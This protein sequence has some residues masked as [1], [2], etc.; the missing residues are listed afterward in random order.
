MGRPRG[1]TC[2]ELD[3]RA[4]E[5]TALV[6]HGHSIRY[7]GHFLSYPIGAIFRLL[8]RYWGSS[9]REKISGTAPLLPIPGH[10]DIEV[11]DDLLSLYPNS[12]AGTSRF[13]SVPVGNEVL[14]S[15]LIESGVTVDVSGSVDFDFSCLGSSATSIR[16]RVTEVIALEHLG[17]RDSEIEKRLGLPSGAVDGLRVHASDFYRD[18]GL[19]YVERVFNRCKMSMFEVHRRLFDTAVHAVVGLEDMIKDRSTAPSLRERCCSQV[20]SLALQRAK[21]V[22]DNVEKFHELGPEFTDAVQRA[23]ETVERERSR[24]QRLSN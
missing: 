8:T 19:D 22:G 24:R 4:G 3:T 13:T 16:G 11:A 9:D 21:A 1:E 12:L 23:K 7:I 15:D 6:L 17:L 20:L 2:K 10:P 14:S 5:V 18:C